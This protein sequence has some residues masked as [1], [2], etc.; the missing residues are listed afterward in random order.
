MKYKYVLD[1][2]SI[3]N[4]DLVNYYSQIINELF[5]EYCDENISYIFLQDRLLDVL[6]DIRVSLAMNEFSYD[7]NS[8]SLACD[9]V[10]IIFNVNHN[11]SMALLHN[12]YDELSEVSAR[13]YEWV[14]YN[15]IIYIVKGGEED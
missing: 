14:Y 11:I 12:N 6:L 8:F 4:I 7:D 2:N 9:L 3:R 13:F 15:D 1:K 5:E 10:G